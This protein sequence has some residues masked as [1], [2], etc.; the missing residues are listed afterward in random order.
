MWSTPSIQRRSTIGA[1]GWTFP[2]LIY[3]K[4]KRKWSEMTCPISSSI[5]TEHQG[6]I[7]KETN[8]RF[9]LFGEIQSGYLSLIFHIVTSQMRPIFRGAI[10]PMALMDGIDL[11]ATEL[12]SLLSYLIDIEE[13][14]PKP[15]PRFPRLFGRMKKIQPTNSLPSPNSKQLKGSAAQPNLT[16]SPRRDSQL[17]QWILAPETIYAVRT[18]TLSVALFA[19]NVSK[20]TVGTYMPNSGVVALL[21]GQVGYCLFFSWSR[22]TRGIFSR[23]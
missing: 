6:P 7:L 11:L 13:N 2:V 12:I 9:P 15:K 3:A 18:A 23:M 19:V 14:Q 17:L 22:L 8:R 4:L 1:S 10:L 16:S 21:L 5:Q 20:T